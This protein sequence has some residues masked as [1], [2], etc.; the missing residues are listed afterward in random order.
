MASTPSATCPSSRLYLGHAHLT[1][2]YWYLTATPEL[3]HYVMQRVQRS[4]EQRP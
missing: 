4:R 3:L 2:T 1:D